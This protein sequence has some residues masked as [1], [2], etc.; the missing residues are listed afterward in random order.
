MNSYR[1]RIASES[2]FIPIYN[3]I[4]ASPHRAKWDMAEIRRRV[5]RPLFLEQIIVFLRGADICGFLTFAFM[6]R[7]SGAHQATGGIEDG[8]WRSGN[9]P[10]IVD[11]FC[12]RDGLRIL[13]RLRADF[14]NAIKTPIRYWRVKHKQIRRMT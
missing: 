14:R 1:W 2:D 13:A 10:W 7:K 11:F 4:Y 12:D 6:D 9:N 5:L 8:D 3:L